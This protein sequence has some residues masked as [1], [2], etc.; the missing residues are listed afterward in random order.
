MAT[1]IDSGMPVQRTRFLRWCLVHVTGTVATAK[2]AAITVLE[3]RRRRR[4]VKKRRK[5][6]EKVNV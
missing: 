3:K 5:K 4:L 1:G 2:V 6:K